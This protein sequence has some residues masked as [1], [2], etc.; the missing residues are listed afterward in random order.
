MGSVVGTVNAKIRKKKKQKESLPNH[1]QA[2]KPNIITHY[3]SPNVKNIFYFIFFIPDIIFIFVDQTN[4]V[5][6]LLKK[7]HGKSN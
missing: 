1:Q 5:F 6:K 3:E 7:Q 4:K 2:N